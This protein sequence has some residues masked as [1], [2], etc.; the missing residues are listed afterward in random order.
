MT[1]ETTLTLGDERDR[2]DDRLDELAALAA[3]ADD[4]SGYRQLASQVETQ[5]SGVAHHA[6][7]HS[8]DATVIIEGLTAGG[9]ARV[10][11][12]LAG[13]GEEQGQDRLPGTRDNAMAAMGLVDAPFVDDEAGFEER[14]AAVAD[15]PVG[16]A[17]WLAARV[18]EETQAD[19]G[20]WQ[21]FGER[22]REAS[23]GD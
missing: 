17:K 10:E 7:Q 9:F 21:S 15:E 1:D 18:N 6:N 14:L 12:Y 5:L 4:P 20:N 2:L 22:Y 16:V 3:E 13:A 11:D 19:E 23:K 8:P